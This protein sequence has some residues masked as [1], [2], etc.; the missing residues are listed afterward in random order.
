MNSK[1]TFTDLDSVYRAISELLDIP[2]IFRRATQAERHI[3]IRRYLAAHR[4]LL[5]LDNLSET[6]VR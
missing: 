4:T 2:A 6:G 5:V 3:T 1:P